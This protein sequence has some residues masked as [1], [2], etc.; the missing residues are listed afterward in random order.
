M[1]V[2]WSQVAVWSIVAVALVLLGAAFHAAFGA[3]AT[4]LQP[5]GK[6][7]GPVIACQTQADAEH[8]RD[9]LAI[10]K[11]D[12]A[13]AYLMA[14]DNTCGAARDVPFIADEAV[15]PVKADKNGRG[16]RLVRVTIESG[17]LFLVTTDEI[18]P[19]GSPT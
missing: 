6:Y 1:T 8:L 11:V 16:W 3:D 7:R 19:P 15:G 12:D 10:G 5:G 9:L 4:V 13:R 17:D 18:G 14:E 2:R